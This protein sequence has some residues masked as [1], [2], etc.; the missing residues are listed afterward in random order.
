[1]KEQAYNIIKTKDSRTQR[2]S[3][4]KKFMEARFKI[5]PQKFEDQT[6]GEIVSLKYVCEHGSSE[7]A[8][9]L[10]SRKIDMAAPTISI[11]AEENL[12]DL[13]DIRVDIIHLEPV[14]AVA[15]PAAAAKEMSTLRFRMGMVEAENTSLRGKIKTMEAIKTGT[16]RQEKRARMEME[17]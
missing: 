7:F 4:L 16:R 17:R 9:S 6:L 12:R 2:Q 10:A 8:G 5:S 14:A 15:F 13:I 11:L 3:N 1:M